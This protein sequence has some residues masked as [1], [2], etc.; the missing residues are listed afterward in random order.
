MYI[1]IKNL[2]KNLGKFVELD[3]LI[4]G[5]PI[6]MMFLALFSFESTRNISLLILVFG[7]FCL[8]PINISNKNRMYKFIIIATRYLISIKVYLKTNEE[9]E[10]KKIDRIIK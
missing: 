8:I 1:T 5:L 9:R 3:D 6:F 2:N 4:F 7:S 10:A